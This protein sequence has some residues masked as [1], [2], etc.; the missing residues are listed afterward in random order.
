ML[1][2]LELLARKVQQANDAGHAAHQAQEKQIRVQSELKKL[3]TAHLETD[4]SLWQH[5]WV[6][7]WAIALDVP[8]WRNHVKD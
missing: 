6:K 3:L 7:H 5:G 8:D 4:S 2:A 1:S